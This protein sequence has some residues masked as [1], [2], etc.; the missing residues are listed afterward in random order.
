[1]KRA[2]S[3]P[4]LL[5]LLVTIS[6]LAFD[7]K[8]FMAYSL[9]TE[10]HDA[11]AMWIEPSTVVLSGW[12]HPIGYKFNVTIC[13][14]LTVACGA[15]MFRLLYNKDHLSM[16]RAHY[17]EDT[18]SEFFENITTIPVSPVHSSFN[19]THNRIDYGEQ[20]A[21]VGP[22]RDPGYGT[23]AWVEF[24]VIAV[25]PEGEEYTSLLDI[26]ES[27]PTK[28]F[29]ADET[30]Q[31]IA[32]T[33]YD[34]VYR[35]H[36]PPY[37]VTIKGHCITENADVAVDVTMDGSPTGFKTPH[38]FSLLGAHNFTVPNEDPSGHSF[39]EWSSGEKTTTITVTHELA[40]VYTANYKIR[41]NLAIDEDTGGTTDPPHGTYAYFGDETA[42]VTAIPSVG[43]VFHHWILDDAPAGDSNPISVWMYKNHRLQAAFNWVGTYDLEISATS[44]GTTEPSS[45]VYTITNGTE[46][47]VKALPDAGWFLERWRLDGVSVGNQNPIT[48]LMDRSHT[49]SAE[50][51]K[52]DVAV[53]R[54]QVRP[55]II[56]GH[57]VRIET[58]V[59]NQ[60]TYT[61]TFSVN[62]VGGETQQV[63]LVP[64]SGKWLLFE[65]AVPST[66]YYEFTVVASVVPG[67]IDT[68]DNAGA[69]FGYI[70]VIPADMRGIGATPELLICCW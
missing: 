29:A 9:P 47:K 45:G 12:E 22:P 69:R 4:T 1:L 13:I 61:E 38:T 49:L 21:T 54:V 60:G 31:K 55:V 70:C 17:T 37:E 57:P 44:D 39:K 34:S 30:W 18:G 26:A 40:G 6:A 33:P 15:W 59:Q 24:T 68:A 19:A 35:F 28:T 25:P 2:C 36:W 46:L 11:N 58:T 43:Y 5:L 65:L 53:V 14:N 52:H 3:I 66:A 42:S 67:E 56:Q 41:F 48:I 62:V 32:L 50:F 16:S 10:P 51:Q 23:L 27:Y 20:W 7:I 8:P 63:T 64:G